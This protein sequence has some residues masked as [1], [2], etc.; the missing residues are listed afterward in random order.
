MADLSITAGSPLAIAVVFR[1]RQG[2]A[3]N[4]NMR[5]EQD[6]QYSSLQHKEDWRF[7]STEKTPVSEAQ[8]SRMFLLRRG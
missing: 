1:S 4:F 2:L 8:R 6:V 7:L 3:R 5:E